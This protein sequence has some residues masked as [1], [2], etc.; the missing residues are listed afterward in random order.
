MEQIDVEMEQID[1][2]GYNAINLIN[3]RQPPVFL[4]DYEQ[5]DCYLNFIIKVSQE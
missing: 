5:L 2:F 4:T 3:I 1:V